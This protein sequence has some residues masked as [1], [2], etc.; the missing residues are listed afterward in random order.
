[1]AAAAEP[2]AGLTG[3]HCGFQWFLGTLTGPEGGLGCSTKEV[4]VLTRQQWLILNCLADQDEPLESVYAAF[5]EDDFSQDPAQ[6]LT[7]LFALYELGCVV[8]R[9]EA[10]PALGQEFPS[11]VLHPAKPTEI[12][13][14]CAEAFEEF[15]ATRDYLA[16]YLTLGSGPYASPTGVPF[17]IWAELTPRGRA[18]RDR[19]KS[20]VYRDW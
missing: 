20:V 8:F 6:L 9:Q 11:R 13:G 19:P 5:A 7:V 3:R 14:D 10:I 16:Y 1:M 4:P 2:V 12:V 15:R 17:G 18:E